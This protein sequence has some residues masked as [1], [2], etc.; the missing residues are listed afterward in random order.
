VYVVPPFVLTCHC[1]VGVGFPLAAVVNVAVAPASTDWLTGCVVIVGAK[2]TVSVTGFVVTLLTEF[3]NT[4][5]Y[6]FPFCAPVV[7]VSVSVADVA[8]GTFVYVVPP[9]VLTCH[10][11]VGVGVPVA[12]AVN[13]AVVPAVTVVLVGCKL[14]NGAE[15]T[16][17]VAAVLVI[18]PAELVN[19]TSY[20]LPFCAVVVPAMTNVVEVAPATFV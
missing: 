4:A 18:V 19:T 7:A 17:R 12:A 13:V 14:I 11:T 5:S 2:S 15:F 20:R 1:T 3:V 9:L 8:P 6:R 10:C 16:V